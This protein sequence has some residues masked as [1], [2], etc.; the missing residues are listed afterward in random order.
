MKKSYIKCI[1]LIALLFL[2]VIAPIALLFLSTFMIPVESK[3][4]YT[5]PVS[6]PMPT[7]RPT[8]S[9]SIDNQLFLL[10]SN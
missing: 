3:S 9:A 1:R 2:S 10:W 4:R 6:T 7:P 8:S 5:I